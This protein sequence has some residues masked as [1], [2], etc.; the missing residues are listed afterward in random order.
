MNPLLFI[1]LAAQAA[2]ETIEIPGAKLKFQL[3]A[4]PGGKAKIGSPD[5][6]PDRKADEPLREVELQPFGMGVHEVT[7]AEFNYFR[8][9]PKDVDAVTR[10]S[11]ADSYFGDAGIPAESFEPKKPLTNIRWHSALMYCEWLSRKTGRYF[12]LPTEAEW[13]HAARAGVATPAPA[14]PGAEAW[15]KPNSEEKTHLGGGKA[16]NA[17]GLRDVLGNVWEYVLEPYAFPDYGPVLKGGCWSSPAREMRYANRQTIPYKWFSE[18]SNLPRSVWWLTASEVSIGFRVVCAADAS[19]RDER[20][21][22]AS[23]FEVR[24]TGHKEKVIKTQGSNAP[25]RAV[26]GEIKNIGDRALDEVELQVF[27]TESDGK[28][29]LTDQSGSKPGRGCFSKCWPVLRN[30]ALGGEV[31]KPLGPGET[32]GFQVDLP[33]SYDLETQKDPKI[34]L[35]GRVTALRFS[36]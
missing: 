26:T 34:T 22:Y 6:D 1:F 21:A 32:R 27:Y 36:K 20:E 24:I 35:S 31:R 10:P 11:K 25:Y 28:P 15:F 29:H 7:W 13:E 19:D 23:K 5:A 14:N 30:S 8:N 33:Q 4:V 9:N 17:F 18:D 2:P 16:A 12:R 3:V